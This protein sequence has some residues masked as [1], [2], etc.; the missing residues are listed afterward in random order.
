MRAVSF[1]QAATNAYRLC[2]PKKERKV[3]SS[4]TFADLVGWG[5]RPRSLAF[6][7]AIGCSLDDFT[8]SSEGILCG[9]PLE[10]SE[11]SLTRFI[12]RFRIDAA[13]GPS[14]VRA[15]SPSCLQCCRA[16]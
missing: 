11:R 14:V 6:L 5:R 10:L 2:R 9:R 3:P 4:Q 8:G 16:D 15:L 12:F 13:H 1:R 7:L